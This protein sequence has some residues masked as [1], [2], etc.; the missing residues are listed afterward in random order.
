MPLHGN[1][2]GLLRSITLSICQVGYHWWRVLV[3]FR[4]RVRIRDISVIRGASELVVKGRLGQLSRRLLAR[5]LTFLVPRRGRGIHTRIGNRNQMTQGNK[6]GRQFDE[7]KTSKNENKSEQ[8]RYRHHPARKI[9]ERPKTAATFFQSIGSTT[10][11]TRDYERASGARAAHKAYEEKDRDLTRWTQQL[12]D[13]MHFAKRERSKNC[14]CCS[15][16]R[17]ESL[18]AGF[19]HLWGAGDCCRSCVLMGKIWFLQRG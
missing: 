2:L 6:K 16:T 3:L 5:L 9:G 8:L 17:H 18:V 19:S 10:T 13:G 1:S 4:V 15:N 7:R 14:G 11:H 12:P